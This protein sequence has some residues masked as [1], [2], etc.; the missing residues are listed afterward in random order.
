MGVPKL[1]CVLS[2]ATKAPCIATEIVENIINQ[3]KVVTDV[4]A[5]KKRSLDSNAQSSSKKKAVGTAQQG[6]DNGKENM[7]PMNKS[8]SHKPAE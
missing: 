1:A 4:L 3:F 7:P 8:S 6:V 2:W 5:G